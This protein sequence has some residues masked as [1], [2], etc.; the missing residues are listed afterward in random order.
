MNAAPELNRFAANLL[1]GVIKANGTFVYVWGKVIVTIVL[2]PVGPT[3]VDKSTKN[4]LLPPL[5]VNAREPP[6]PAP[7]PV[8]P[9]GVSPTVNIWS[10][11][12]IIFRIW[13]P[14]N[15][16]ITS[17]SSNVA[18][19]PKV[20]LKLEIR[21]TAALEPLP[22]STCTVTVLPVPLGILV[23]IQALCHLQV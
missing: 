20:I 16:E 10:D 7:L 17:S 6:I 13:P 18:L 2:A 3:P 15:S 21:N 14:R 11:V 23:L 12:L 5:K 8:V 9:V 19:W 22:H 1:T 4:L